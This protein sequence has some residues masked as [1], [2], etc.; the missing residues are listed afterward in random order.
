MGTRTHGAPDAP[1]DPRAPRVPHAPAAPGA[2]RSGHAQ[3]MR[4][5]PAHMAV[6]IGKRVGPHHPGRKQVRN[7][8]GVAIMVSGGP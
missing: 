4:G 5:A 7:R 3:N 6:H 8:G 2:P 1:R